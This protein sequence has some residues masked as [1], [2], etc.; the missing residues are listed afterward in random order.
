MAA[1]AGREVV[2]ERRFFPRGDAMN[3]L[4]AMLASQGEEMPELSAIAQEALGRRMSGAVVSMLNGTMGTNWLGA[5][6]MLSE[7][8]S[9]L[10]PEGFTPCAVL[11][12]YGTDVD[13][14]VI[15]IQSGEGVASATASFVAAEAIQGGEGLLSLLYTEE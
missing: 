7:G 14:L 4:K 3:A 2:S 6:S 9:F 13:V 5:A 8:E 11:L 12:D 10:M 1:N 15:F